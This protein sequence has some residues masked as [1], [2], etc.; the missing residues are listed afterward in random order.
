MLTFSFSLNMRIQFLLRGIILLLAFLRAVS[1]SGEDPGPLRLEKEISLPEV[2]GRIDHFSADEAG[3]RLFIAA[4]ENGSVEIVDVRRGERTAEIKGLKEPQGVYYDGKTGRLFVATG[5]DGKLRIYDG[6]TLVGQH[7]LELGGD[8]D[9]VRYD[10][11]TGDIWVGY[12]NGGIGIVNSTG[13]RVGSVELG[14]HPESFQ[15]EESGN[16]AYAN[17]PTQFGVSVID[18]QNHTIITKWGLGWAFANYPMALDDLNKRLFVGCRLP[19]RLVVLDTNSGRIVATLPT[20]GDT[21]DV[22]C[23]A[24]RRLIYVIGGEGSVEI[25]RQHDPDHYE[26]AQRITTAL[27]ARTGFFLPNSGRLYV[28][29]PHRGSQAAKVLVYTIEGS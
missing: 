18:R 9:N 2:E 16:R 7:T 27:G 28:A 5:G 8:A 19:A 25:L 14:T 13:Q 1:A 17:V 15:F 24:A 20:V 6:K 11:Q 10:R 21:D 29:V 4:L 12:G 3:Q 23:D 22:F 26:Q